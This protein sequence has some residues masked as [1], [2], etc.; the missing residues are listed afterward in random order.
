MWLGGSAS[1]A[2]GRGGSSVGAGA[3]LS[4]SGAGICPGDGSG[5]GEDLFSSLLVVAWV[6]LVG[7]LALGALTLRK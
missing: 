7:V 4:S 6:W 3:L 1:A 2:A 5:A